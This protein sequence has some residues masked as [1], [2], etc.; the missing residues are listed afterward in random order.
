MPGATDTITLNKR[1]LKLLKE[2]MNHHGW[3]DLLVSYPNKDTL[4]NSNSQIPKRY[5][6]LRPAFRMTNDEIDGLRKKLQI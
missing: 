5:G 6:G 1:E 3:N 4:Y 2:Y